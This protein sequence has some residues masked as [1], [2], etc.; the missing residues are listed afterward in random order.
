MSYAIFGAGRSGDF[1]RSFLTPERQAC[2]VDNFQAGK[3][4]YGLP[5]VSLET[6]QKEYANMPLVIAS[7][8]YWMDMERDVLRA[9]ITR[10]FV[11]RERDMADFAHFLPGYYLYRKHHLIGYDEI[12]ANY[13]VYQYSKLAIV[14]T[15]AMLPYLLL[16]IMEQA[17]ESEIVGIVDVHGRSIG[18]FG[19]P[20]MTLEKAQEQADMLIMNVPRQDDCGVRETLWDADVPYLDLYD[21]D[22]FISAFQHPELARF[23]DIHKGERCFLIGNGPSLRMEDLDTLAAHH[24]ICFGVNRIFRAYGETKWRPTYYCCCDRIAIPTVIEDVLRGT[25]DATTSF[26]A[27]DFHWTINSYHSGIQYLHCEMTPFGST[28]EPYFSSDITK[29]VYMGF[30]VIYD[31]CLQLATYMGFSEIY[32]LGVDSNSTGGFEEAQ[33]HG[34]PSYF[35]P[36]E[37]AYY[38]THGWIPPWDMMMRAMEKAERYA[39]RNGIRIYNATRGGKLEAFERVDFDALFS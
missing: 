25:M 27:D 5:I 37:A 4:K 6:Y 26:I 1:A 24:E 18:A 15:N 22:K 9:G 35:N 8:R 29:C 17:P 16:E 31:F 21:I 38:R 28:G 30:S 14:G 32:L 34:I 2:F 36:E 39:R 7:E 20:A 3:E 33:N 11:F 10:Y 12:L 13:R 23:K 19:V